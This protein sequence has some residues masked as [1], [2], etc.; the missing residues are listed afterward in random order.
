MEWNSNMQG[1]WGVGGCA[2]LE[3]GMHTFGQGPS[4]SQQGHTCPAVGRPY[5]SKTVAT[6]DS[7]SSHTVV[8]ALNS[9]SHPPARTD[10]KSAQTLT[11]V[12]VQHYAIL[13]P[14]SRSFPKEFQTSAHN[15]NET[16]RI[17]TEIQPAL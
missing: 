9:T 5:K 7:S 14:R 11:T 6:D 1:M 2:R 13:L 3:R 10:R 17:P 4:L 12:L 16:G 8:P 15:S